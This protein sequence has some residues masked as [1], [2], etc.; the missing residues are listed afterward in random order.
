MNH[1]KELHSKLTQIKNK[2]SK[3]GGRFWVLVGSVTLVALLIVVQL[4]RLQ[5]LLSKKY[6]DKAYTQYVG[7]S[8]NSLE[9]GNIYFSRKDGTLISAATVSNGFKITVNPSSV[10]DPH[11][12]YKDIAPYTKLTED[13]FIKKISKKDDTYEE[14]AFRLNEK[15]AQEIKG[16]RIQGITL[17]PESWRTY[18]GGRLASQVLGFVGFKG[19]IASGQYGLERQYDSTLS[20]GQSSSVV[21]FF[22]EIF[23]NIDNGV[24]QNNSKIGNLVTTIEPTVQEYLE[25]KLK[26][27][28]N[29]WGSEQVGGVIMD[30]K[31][32]EIVAMA[33]L[34][35]FDPNTFNTEK[36]IKSFSNPIVESVFEP[37]SVV[38]ILSMSAGL[39]SRVV[40]P[41]TY[42][43]DTGSVKLNTETIHN[44]GKKSYGYVSMQDVLGKSLN[45]GVTFVML[46][47]GR[48]L[49]RSYFYKFGLKEKTGIDL[50]N[51]LTNLVSSLESHRDIEYATAAFGQGI[52]LTPISFLRATA[53]LANGGY[54]VTPHIVK[55]IQYADGTEKVFTYEKGSQAITPET[56]NAIS[57]MLSTVVDKSLLSGTVKLPNH[58][59][60]AKTGT[61]QIPKPGGGY[62]PNIYLHTMLA[63]FPAYDARYIVFLYNLKPNADEFSA[64]TLAPTTMDI[65]QFLMTYY[66]VPGDR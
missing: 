15:Q 4:F 27:V 22:A 55:K 53:A 5:V 11:L 56:S 40:T 48:D 63:Y 3:F 62:Y 29:E 36:S 32:G 19:D 23:S 47:M 37:G 57:T 49:F 25:K 31:N 30:P 35:D 14:V 52:A 34:P 50:P 61:A 38:K 46:K 13:E 2:D 24:E 18:P 41:T 45:T 33:N 17:Y 39:D 51:E 6:T 64:K 66:N 7:I 1:K 9:R 58:T 42:Y 65:G 54:L 26:S 12:V 59:A 21:N 28:K 10:S 43:T 20:L 44:A 16:K 8:G 60:A